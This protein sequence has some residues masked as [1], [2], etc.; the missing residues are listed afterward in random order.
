MKRTNSPHVCDNQRKY[1]KAGRGCNPS[2][3]CP[4]LTPDVPAAIP[5]YRPSPWRWAGRAVRRGG[6]FPALSPSCVGE[7]RA[8]CAGL[9]SG[10]LWLSSRAQTCDRST[11]R[12]WLGGSP[13]IAAAA[14]RI[15]APAFV[16]S[17]YREREREDLTMI[18]SSKKQPGFPEILST[19]DLEA[20]RDKE[21]LD[22]NS[23]K[24]LKE[25]QCGLMIGGDGG[26][27]AMQT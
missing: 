15:P 6:V 7:S 20:L 17:G 1:R 10:V 11:L 22:L 16:C 18:D 12:S 2:P 25:G 27:I 4:Y 23:Q 8:L 5:Q 14:P 24:S 3:L 19:G 26:R 9:M 13:T 21:C